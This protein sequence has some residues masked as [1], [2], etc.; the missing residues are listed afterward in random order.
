MMEVQN[1]LLLITTS[2]IQADRLPSGISPVCQM[3]LSQTFL[4]GLNPKNGLFNKI[5]GYF[6]SRAYLF[7]TEVFY[8]KPSKFNS[9]KGEPQ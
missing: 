2:T 9:Y 8:H 1:A 7:L 4:T 3:S 6:G 5:L